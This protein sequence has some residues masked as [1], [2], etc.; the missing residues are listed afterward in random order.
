MSQASYFDLTKS[1]QVLGPGNAVDASLDAR[2]T[3]L[4]ARFAG[5]YLADVSVSNTSATLVAT[6]VQSGILKTTPAV[7]ITLTTPTA[8]ALL[9][10]EAAVS[11]VVVGRGYEFNV[12]NLA[13]VTY[14]VTLAAGNGVTLIGNAV[15]GPNSNGRFYLRFTNVTAS[16]EAVTVIR[17]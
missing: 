6:D 15:V 13:S 12:V 11:P 3:D 17:L 8:V 2:L 16:T 5:T 7:A 14:T 10:A 9:A 1:G 4:S